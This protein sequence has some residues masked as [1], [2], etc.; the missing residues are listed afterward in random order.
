MLTPPTLSALPP[1]FE[2]DHLMCRPANTS[3][4]R[5]LHPRPGFTGPAAAFVECC[6]RATGAVSRP[7]GWGPLLGEAR[8]N[9]LLQRGYGDVPR[10]EGVQCGKS[11]RWARAELVEE[12]VDRLM[13]FVMV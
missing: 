1:G 9:V 10:C 6:D 11:K 4:L 5:P 3:C 7:A 2:D 12:A 13:R 8:R